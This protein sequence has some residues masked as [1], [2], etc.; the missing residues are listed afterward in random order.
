ML[1]EARYVSL[2]FHSTG[3]SKKDASMLRRL[4]KYQESGPTRDA[5]VV[6]VLRTGNIG[7]PNVA[8]C[9]FTGKDYVMFLCS[10]TFKEGTAAFFSCH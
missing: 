9:L 5:R 6:V 10:Y 1:F 3:S 8:P 7:F 4:K 2:V